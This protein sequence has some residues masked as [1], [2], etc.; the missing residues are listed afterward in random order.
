MKTAKGLHV[1]IA[2][3]GALEDKLYITTRLRAPVVAVRRSM[4]VAKTEGIK[5]PF[6]SLEYKGTINA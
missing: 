3:F 2:D 1:W 4:Q 5:S 6:R